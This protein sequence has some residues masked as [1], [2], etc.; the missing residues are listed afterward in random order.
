MA[1]PNS[2]SDPGPSRNP[3]DAPDARLTPSARENSRP[4]KTTR[5]NGGAPAPFAVDCVCGRTR[6]VT[7]AQAGSIVPCDCGAEIKVPSLG[8]LRELAGQGR[9]ESGPLDTIRRMIATGEL[10][11][12]KVCVWT[13]EP[14]DDLL[15]VWVKI[16][17]MERSEVGK[18]SS[19]WMILLLGFWALPLI[20]ARKGKGFVEA[21]H[22][23]IKLPLRVTLAAQWK[24]R[25]LEAWR[26]K[27]LLRKTPE[28]AELLDRNPL[29]QVG[30]DPP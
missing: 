15:D 7:S 14:S 28:Y 6:G 2:S 22:T 1:T 30:C 11:P 17:Q 18:E 26:L 20:W 21:S 16:P 29:A 24:V 27:R 5:A 12:G 25:S 9:Y 3:Y 13:G 8:R 10:P 23:V 19:P 4:S